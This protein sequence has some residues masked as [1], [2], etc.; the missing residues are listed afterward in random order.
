MIPLAG[1]FILTFGLI[2][3]SIIV[4]AALNVSQAVRIAEDNW[5]AFGAGAINRAKS[6]LTIIGKF[7]LVLIPQS[8]SLMLVSLKYRYRF[9][10]PKTCGCLATR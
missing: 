4:V 5:N 2:L 6:I 3:S 9:I 8:I 7:I 1:P 10:C